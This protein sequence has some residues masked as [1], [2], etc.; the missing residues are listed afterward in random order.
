MECMYIVLY[1]DY[2]L[3]FYK[4]LDCIWVEVIELENLEKYDIFIFSNNIEN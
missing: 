1:L 4:S 2:Y 3:F